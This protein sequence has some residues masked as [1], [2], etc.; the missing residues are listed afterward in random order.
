[1]C[2]SGAGGAF[3]FKMASKM[4][5]K[6]LSGHNHATINSGLMILVSIPL[7]YFIYLFLFIYLFIFFFLGGGKE[8]IKTIK[9]MLAH[10]KRYVNPVW[11]PRWPPK[12]LNG[13]RSVTV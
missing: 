13:H 3:F 8:C 4:A 9:I 10:Y 11:C 12:T 2:V 1:M 5:P 6:T 7:F